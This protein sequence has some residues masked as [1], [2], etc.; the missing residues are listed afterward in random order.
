MQNND[1]GSRYAYLDLLATALTA[2]EKNL[3]LLIERLDRI[4]E[5]LSKIPCAETVVEE[6]KGSVQDESALSDEA[7]EALL[8]AARDAAESKA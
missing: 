8:Q 5:N 6:G 2:H 3:S 7:T 1:E 4:V